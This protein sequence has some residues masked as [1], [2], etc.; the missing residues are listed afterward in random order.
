[1]VFSVFRVGRWPLSITPERNNPCDSAV[2]LGIS[3]NSKHEVVVV[4]AEP[5]VSETVRCPRGVDDRRSDE[6]EGCYGFL[7]LGRR[8]DDGAGDDNGRDSHAHDSPL[9]AQP[10][11]TRT[12]ID[13]GK[14]R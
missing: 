1:M 11:S 3:L 5:R 4:Q 10:E 7:S 13:D 6:L 9:P 14:P 2:R 8:R 12:T